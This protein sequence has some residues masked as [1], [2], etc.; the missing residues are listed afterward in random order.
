MKERGH[1]KVDLVGFFKNFLLLTLTDIDTVTDTE[2]VL[3]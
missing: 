2:V 3:V 1:I